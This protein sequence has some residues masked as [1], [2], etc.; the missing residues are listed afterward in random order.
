MIGV[1]RF[2]KKGNLSP[3]CIGPLKILHCVWPVA[4]R[5]ALPPSL[6]RVHLVFHMSMLKKYHGDGDYIIKWDLVL[7]EINL[8]YEEKPIAI[9]D[10]DVRKLRTKEIKFVKVPWKHHPVE[11]NTWEIEKDV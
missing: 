2:G 6:S 11:E 8:Q 5:L 1:M 3:R 4:Y 9:L 7:L 10:R